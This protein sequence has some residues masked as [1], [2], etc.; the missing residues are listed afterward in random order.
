[1]S[2]K[3]IGVTSGYVMVGTVATQLL[4]WVIM[5]GIA[6]LDGPKT[7]GIYALAQSFAT[8]IQYLS[9]LSIRQ[10][11]LTLQVVDQHISD[12]LF[13]RATAPAAAFLIALLLIFITS[14]D[15]TLTFICASLFLLKYIE[16]FYDIIYAR[17]Q[18]QGEAKQLAKLAIVRS[19]V[20]GLIFLLF[21]YFTRNLYGSMFVVA[22]QQTII[23]F[24]VREYFH[25]T[26][27]HHA[28]HR[29]Y[30]ATLHHRLRL[31]IELAPM[32]ASLVIMSFNTSVPRFFLSSMVGIPEL[33][34]FAAVGSLTSLGAIAVGAV[35]QTLLQPLAAA[36]KAQDERSFWEKII[37]P[38]LLVIFLCITAAIV[39][40]FC[41]S[42]VMGIIYGPAFK[43]SGSLLVS[44]TLGAGTVFSASI[45]CNGIFAANLKR[46]LFWCQTSTVIVTIISTLALVPVL[47]VQGA[48]VAIGLSG[49]FQTIVCIVILRRFWAA[50]RHHQARSLVQAAV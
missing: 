28:A 9:Y 38:M 44:G 40:H 21:Y 20:S 17:M 48:F 47:G 2:W 19:F 11:Y 45:A 33:G 6:H 5:T 1:M 13:L 43:T 35:G 12:F 4:Q 23:L 39:L 16:G 46:P 50:C 14:G 22:I 37:L 29:T 26:V 42:M 27:D 31:A 25:D 32:T 18:Q 30:M 7:L 8:P 49:I 10:R 41:G 36:V 15:S 3:K 24:F 34:R